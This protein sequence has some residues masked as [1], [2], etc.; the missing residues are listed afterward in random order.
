[1]NARMRQDHDEAA[2][3]A[4]ICACG[5]SVEAMPK[6]GQRGIL[7]AEQKLRIVRKAADCKKRGDI[8][9]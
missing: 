4:S 7:A 2:Q 5:V 3:S 1:M 9:R 6:A 8:G